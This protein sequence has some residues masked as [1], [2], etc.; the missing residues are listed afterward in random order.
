ML[1]VW[2][3]I[4]G[5]INSHIRN[6][7]KIITYNSLKSYCAGESDVP[8]LLMTVLWKIIDPTP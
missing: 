8:S 3:D 7:N 1:P 4:L 2:T 6:I 5:A